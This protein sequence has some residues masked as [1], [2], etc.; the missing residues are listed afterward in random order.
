[1]RAPH[2]S[3]KAEALIE[4]RGPIERAIVDAVEQELTGFRGGWI[5]RTKAKA[6]FKRDYST[7]AITKA[8]LALGYHR[9]GR[10][11]VPIFQ[12]EH[13]KPELYHLNRS[14]SGANYAFAQ[15][16]KG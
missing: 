2:T 3:S 11:S 8:I 4:S 9:I 7:Q 16:Y 14:E 15:G 10:A 5:S 1:M 12:E 6:L 13:S